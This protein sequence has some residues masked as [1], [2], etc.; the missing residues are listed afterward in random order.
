L[1]TI[2]ADLAARAAAGSLLTQLPGTLGVVTEGEHGMAIAP[3]KT[4]AL[5]PKKVGVYDDENGGIVVAALVDDANG[6]FTDEW[7]EAPRHAGREMLAVFSVAIGSGS[8]LETH[9]AANNQVSP[10]LS[11]RNG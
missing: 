3:N 9:V 6:A 1:W 4:Y 10:C 2:R 8:L 5:R 7:I 11:S